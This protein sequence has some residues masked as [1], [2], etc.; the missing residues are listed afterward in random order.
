MTSKPQD[1]LPD[2]AAPSAALGPATTEE[3]Q[4]ALAEIRSASERQENAAARHYD[5]LQATLAGLTEQLD[6][7]AERLLGAPARPAP[8]V[9][10]RVV[11]AAP[12]KNEAKEEKDSGDWESLL[13]G[14]ELASQDELEIDRQEL[15]TDA[16]QGDPAAW[17]LLGQLLVFRAANSDRLPVLLKDIGEAYYRWRPSAGAGDPFQDSLISWLQ[18]TCA[19]GGLA[20]TIEL[21]H[22]G[23]R[24]DSTR[25]NTRE[26]GV[27]VSAVYG[28]VVLRDNGSVYTKANVSVK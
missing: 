17:A 21:V 22:M 14:P 26:R 13:L 25:H 12:E 15:L 10:S 28:W 18:Q 20:N 23:D 16:R 1:R 2:L 3:L 24:Y 8:V 9:E 11:T 6:G 19:S 7:L 27:E 4:Q 5:E